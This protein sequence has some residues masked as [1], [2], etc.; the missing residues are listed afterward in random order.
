M[1]KFGTVITSLA[2]LK[3]ISFPWN[4]PFDPHYVLEATPV[5]V[6][7]LCMH[8]HVLQYSPPSEK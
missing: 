3:I 8:M 1:P 7:F 2:L 5:T 4:R 6:H